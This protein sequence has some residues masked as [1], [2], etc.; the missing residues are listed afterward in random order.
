MI[1]FEHKI[2]LK[3]LAKNIL[4]IKNYKFIYKINYK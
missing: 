3:N 4:M 1:K 2:M